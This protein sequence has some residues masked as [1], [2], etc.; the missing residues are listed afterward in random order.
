MSVTVSRD[1]TSTASG[2]LLVN[3]RFSF[4]LISFR[5]P[6]IIF[7]GFNGGRDFPAG[8]VSL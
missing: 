8:Y 3:A 2:S 5:V 6:Y 7:S 1:Q 4:S